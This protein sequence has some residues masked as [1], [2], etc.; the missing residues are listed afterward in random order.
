MLNGYNVFSKI[1]AD[2]K[3]IYPWS[4]RCNQNYLDTY[5]DEFEKYYKEYSEN[6]NVRKRKIRA[7]DLDLTI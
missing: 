4:K 5:G 1:I 6:V 3:D 7:N 2:K